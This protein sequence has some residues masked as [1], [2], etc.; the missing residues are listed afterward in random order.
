MKRKVLAMTLALTMMAGTGMTAF[1]ADTSHTTH[2]NDGTGSNTGAEV[3]TGTDLMG[4]GAGETT[5]G[6]TDF[7]INV[8]KDAT[9]GEVIIPGEEIIKGADGVCHYEVTWNYEKGTK[10]SVTVPLYVCMYGYGGNGQVVTPAENAY[11]MTNNSTYTDKRTADSVIACYAVTKIE[12]EAEHTLNDGDTYEDSYIK[13]LETLLFGANSGKTLT[14][15]EK[16]GQYGYY[17]KKNGTTDDYHIVKLSDCDTVHTAETTHDDAADYFYRDAKNE[18]TATT[19]DNKTITKGDVQY[20]N[21]N[22]TGAAL[23]VTVP[24]IQAEVNTWELISTNKVA[25]LTAGQIAMSINGLDLS[26]VVA[27]G[28]S[29]DIKNLNWTVKGGTTNNTLNLPIKA[30]IAGGSVNEE[31]CVPVVR[32]TYTVAPDDAVVGGN[33][34]AAATTGGN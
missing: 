13:P 1:A 5:S 9:G 3:S 6:S 23:D 16:S 24:T 27:N 29:M 28:G 8:D 12:S 34:Y 25:D 2:G 30:A 11:Q 10:L 7:Y 19:T 14:D 26:K 4:N 31:G 22:Q 17:N 15:T 21:G 18:V 33:N 20:A 32:V